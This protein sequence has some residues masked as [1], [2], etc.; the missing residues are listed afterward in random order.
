MAKLARSWDS[1]KAPATFSCLNIVGFNKTSNAVLTTSRANHHHVFHDQWCEGAGITQ[2]IVNHLQLPQK[3]TGLAI[4]GN[5]IG[6]QSGHEQ[7]VAKHG[8]SA[9]G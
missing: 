7:L 2:G 6:V 4:K 9:I 5:D 8:Q 1:V 3:A